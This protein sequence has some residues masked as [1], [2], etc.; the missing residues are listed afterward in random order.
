MDYIGT[1]SADPL[2]LTVRFQDDCTGIRFKQVAARLKSLCWGICGDAM[3]LLTESGFE[4]L[5]FKARDLFP[6][7]CG[8]SFDA[9]MKFTVD[10]KAV[11]ITPKWKD[12]GEGCIKVYGDVQWADNA[13][14]GIELY[15]AKIRY[16]SDERCLKAKIPF[17]YA[18]FVTALQPKKLAWAGFKGDESEYVKLGFCGPANCDAGY[19]VDLTAYF[20]RSGTLFGISRVLAKAFVPITDNFVL[21][22]A[23]GANIV[24]GEPT[25][26][27][28]WE[29]RLL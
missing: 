20:Q 12:V 7:C 21:N 8:I 9:S 17:P 19:S 11:S 1:L 4:Y 29:L 10:E 2:T 14:G 25:L 15:G 16:R 18:E 5:E 6:I 26:D 24:S 13:V 28:G 23:F 3:L 27:L 22:V